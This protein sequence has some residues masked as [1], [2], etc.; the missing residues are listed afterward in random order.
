MSE[1]GKVYLV[2]DLFLITDPMS[3]PWGRVSMG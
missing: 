2:S 1:K 3:L